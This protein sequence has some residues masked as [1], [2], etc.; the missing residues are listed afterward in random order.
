[1]EAGKTTEKNPQKPAEN[2][3]KVEKIQK[4]K[5]N[6]KCSGHCLGELKEVLGEIKDAI[7]LLGEKK[8]ESFDESSSSSGTQEL[9]GNNNNIY[10]GARGGRGRGAPRGRR[11]R[12]FE[13]YYDYQPRDRYR[14]AGSAGP[15]RY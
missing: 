13:P 6:E 2:D 3:E 7:L 4:I 12:F 9:A 15:R 5:K 8:E 1:M 10:R 14:R 11:I